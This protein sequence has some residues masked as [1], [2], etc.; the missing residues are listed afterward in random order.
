MRVE[1]EGSEGT[2]STNG[3]GDGSYMRSKPDRELAVFERTEIF[4]AANEEIADEPNEGIIFSKERLDVGLKLDGLWS[5][6]EGEVPLE[7]DASLSIRREE[8]AQSNSHRLLLC[9]ESCDPRHGV[10]DGRGP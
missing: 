2:L 5:R 6:R 7:R 8:L 1:R 4:F 3:L 9:F 10:W